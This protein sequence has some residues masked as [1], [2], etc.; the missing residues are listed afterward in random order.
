M[1]DSSDDGF[2]TG[3]FGGEIVLAGN[4]GDGAVLTF[5]AGGYGEDSPVPHVG[6]RDRRIGQPC[7]RLVGD[8]PTD[9]GRTGLTGR[10]DRDMSA[11]VST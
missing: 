1:R 11:I 6:D 5:T 10:R 4:E 9:T 7:G 3:S 2:E 8:N